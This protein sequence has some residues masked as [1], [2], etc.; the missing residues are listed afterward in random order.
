MMFA[1]PVLFNPVTRSMYRSVEA[2]GVRD[3]LV[4]VFCVPVYAASDPAYEEPLFIRR[5]G[6]ILWA[7]NIGINDGLYRERAQC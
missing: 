1:S 6:H 3:R 2:T 5:R 4:Y 7:T